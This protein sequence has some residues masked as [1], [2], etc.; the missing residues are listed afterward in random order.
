MAIVLDRTQNSTLVDVAHSAI[1][2]PGPK[3]ADFSPGDY[4]AISLVVSRALLFEALFDVLAKCQ[5]AERLP[6]FRD[7]IVAAADLT[8]PRDAVTLQL[9]AM[10]PYVRPS[11]QAGAFEMTVSGYTL[12]GRIEVTIL[13][14][15]SART[16]NKFEINVGDLKDIAKQV[17]AAIIFTA[18]TSH[19]VAGGAVVYDDKNETIFVCSLDVEFSGNKDDIINRAVDDLISTGD[20][21]KDP[22][23]MWKARQICLYRAGFDPGP[24]DGVY[25]PK[26]KAAESA[27]SNY[28][29]K[30]SVN[31]RSRNFAMFVLKN[32]NHKY[33]KLAPNI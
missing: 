30:I 16:K 10:R 12:T 9:Q 5:G 17:I 3:Y 2:L 31:W 33:Q 23:A 26:T 24:I 8:K 11:G 21:E 22:A 28:H 18:L 19:P 4:A 7:L 14:L 15:G 1:I 13:D 25:G 6:D 27:F 29:N 32:T 20:P